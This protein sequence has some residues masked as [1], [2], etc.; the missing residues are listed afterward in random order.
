MHTKQ[1]DKKHYQFK[2]YLDKQRWMSLWHQLDEILAL[3]PRRVIE[4][5]PGPGL[6]KAMA[7]ALGIVVETLDID[8]E[9][10]PDHLGSAIN[11][12]FHD[13]TY[14]VA[15]AFQMLE[16]LPFKDS[17]KAFGE[18]TRVARDK[19]IISLPDA[20]ILWR[21]TINIPGI[22]EQFFW[23]PRPRWALKKHRF[24]GQ[25][26]WEIN[27][28]GYELP[29]VIEA[30]ETAGNAKLEKTYRVDQNPYHRFFVFTKNQ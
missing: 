29:Q 12:P 5:G 24:D 10:N 16:H 11:L 4:I 26:F 1:V 6:L 18:I 21:Q 27:K 19:V 30:L 7:S 14:D 15:C 20:K 17:L 3:A 9:L 28:A 22:G 23:I 8:P 13:D 25:H 2:D